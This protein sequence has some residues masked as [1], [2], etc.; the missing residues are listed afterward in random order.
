[1][2]WLES[3][4]GAVGD[5]VPDGPTD[6]LPVGLPDGPPDGPGAVGIGE[7]DSAG[8]TEKGSRPVKL[9]IGGP[10]SGGGLGELRDAARS[11]VS[12]WLLPALPKES[13]SLKPL[14]VAHVGLFRQAPGLEHGDPV[15]AT[16]AGQ[17]GPTG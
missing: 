3:L 11:F 15:D 2:F 10:P 1:M 7:G 8:G 13:L 17:G 4:P 14:D 9:W 5:G 12:V 16:I 6:G